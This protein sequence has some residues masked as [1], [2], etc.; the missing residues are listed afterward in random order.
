[1]I[2]KQ[3]SDKIFTKLSKNDLDQCLNDFFE[4]YNIK[5]KKMKDDAIIAVYGSRKS[6]VLRGILA[7]PEILPVKIM[8]NLVHKK[9][10]IKLLIHMKDYYPGILPMGYKHKYPKILAHLMNNLKLNIFNLEKLNQI[11]DKNTCSNCG[12]HIFDENQRFCE[13]CGFE[14]N[15]MN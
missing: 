15:P 7:E 13:T 12:N 3:L 14:L 1:M 5:I 6:A 8:I 11:V 2:K 4:Q 9:N 10:G